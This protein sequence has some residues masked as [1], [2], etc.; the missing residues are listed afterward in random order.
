GFILGGATNKTW[1]SGLLSKGGG[2]KPAYSTFAAA[3]K[4]IDGQ[5]QT[6]N[7]HAKTFTVKVDVP[8]LAYHD[9]PGTLVGVT[10]RIY[11]G[12]AV[13]GIG[14]PRSIIA[15]DQTVSFK[16]KFK[17]AA[18]ASYLMAV[19][20]NDRHG[21]HSKRTIALVTP[22]ASSSTSSTSSTSSS[23]SSKK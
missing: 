13:A 22:T 11:Q 12:K 3:A 20:V 4:T 1:F 18:G 10:Y 8:F 5:T 17:P 6:V 9:F 23:T 2:K 7:P 19:D 15:A 16:V 14:Q 21:Q